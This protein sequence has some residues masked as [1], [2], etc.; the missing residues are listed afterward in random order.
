MLV[1][2]MNHALCCGKKTVHCPILVLRVGGGN[3][4]VDVV[5]GSLRLSVFMCIERV[6]WMGFVGCMFLGVWA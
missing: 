4:R 6:I 1:L 5:G 2:A 3:S